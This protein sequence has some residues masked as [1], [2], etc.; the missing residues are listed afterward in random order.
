M[1]AC[2]AGRASS[3]SCNRVSAGFADL[4]HLICARTHVTS[5]AWVALSRSKERIEVCTALTRNCEAAGRFCVRLYLAWFADFRHEHLA[6]IWA[7][8]TYGAVLAVNCTEEG[9]LAI[10][11]VIKLS[12]TRTIPVSCSCVA[13]LAT[14]EELADTVS[15]GGP[16]VRKAFNLLSTNALV[17]F[18][19]YCAGVLFT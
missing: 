17:A 7:V 9:E 10:V 13:F 15:S 18:I 12:D 11:A 19:T 1:H 4:W 6:I 2:I 5:R 16:L 14:F 3:S 8:V